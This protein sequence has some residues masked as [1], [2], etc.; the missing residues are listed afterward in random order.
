M[1]N[2]FDDC[3]ERQSLVWTKGWLLKVRRAVALGAAN[4]H[5]TS[6]E[7]GRALAAL[8]ELV[9]HQINETPKNVAELTVT[10]PARLTRLGGG[11]TGRMVLPRHCNAAHG[12]SEESKYCVCKLVREGKP[13]RLGEYHTIGKSPLGLYE[14]VDSFKWLSPEEFELLPDQPAEALVPPAFCALSAPGM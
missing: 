12:H 1:E 7:M 14:V 6:Y 11:L 9:G 3:M 5:A 13:I 2:E 4:P 10:I 8:L